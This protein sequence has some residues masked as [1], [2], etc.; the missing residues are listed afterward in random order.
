MSETPAVIRDLDDYVASL[1]KCATE[2][3][4][5]LAFLAEFTTSDE[6]NLDSPGEYSSW[7]IAAVSR[8]N[9]RFVQNRIELA[10]ILTTRL[11]QT[12]A[13]LRAGTIDEYKASRVAAATEVLSDELAT[14][15]EERVLPRAGGM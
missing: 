12:M 9:P 4:K 14:Q 6:D 13:A 8:M 15:V 5:Q 1:R 10:H 7:E 11:P 2:A 3:A